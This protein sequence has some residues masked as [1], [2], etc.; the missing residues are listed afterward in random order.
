MHF[1]VSKVLPVIFKKCFLAFRNTARDQHHLGWQVHRMS[2]VELYLG[3]ILQLCSFSFCLWFPEADHQV[4]AHPPSMI[5]NLKIAK[6]D[7]FLN[8]CDYT[9]GFTWARASAERGPTWRLGGISWSPTNLEKETNPRFLDN[10]HSQHSVWDRL[11]LSE[12]GH[13]VKDWHAKI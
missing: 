10:L 4:L 6:F 8:F 9:R 12:F 7:I 5:P 1:K 3:L 2:L 13:V 11:I